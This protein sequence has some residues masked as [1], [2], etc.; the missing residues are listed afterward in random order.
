MSNISWYGRSFTDHKPCVS[1]LSSTH[2]NRRLR[3]MT[4]K[5]QEFNV[6]IVYRQGKENGN[7]DALSKQLWE[8]PAD[9]V[10]DNQLNL[11]AQSSWAGRCGNTPTRMNCHLSN[12]VSERKHVCCVVWI[13]CGIIMVVFSVF[14]IQSVCN[15]AVWLRGST[16]PWYIYL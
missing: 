2:L 12:C 5:L 13:T 14:S 4:L 15:R 3:S 1:L 11:L 6:K 8:E 10:L 7:V 9:R 16:L